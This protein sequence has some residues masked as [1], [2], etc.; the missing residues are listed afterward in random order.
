MNGVRIIRVDREVYAEIVRHGRF[1]DSINDA[2][3]RRL[4]MRPIQRR[5]LRRKRRP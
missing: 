3:R 1:G 5:P 4:G 2:L